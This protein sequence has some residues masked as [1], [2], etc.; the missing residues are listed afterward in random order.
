ARGGCA[1]VFPFWFYA[2]E[3]HSDFWK[4]DTAAET[5]KLGH[6]PLL[7]CYLLP[8]K[9][10]ACLPSNA[11]PGSQG[12]CLSRF[13]LLPCASFTFPTSCLSP[14]MRAPRPT[15]SPPTTHFTPRH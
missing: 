5:R 6:P 8:A 15:P 1:I 10:H 12:F 11:T 14:A 2:S 9:Q 13:C 7:N 4:F 3:R